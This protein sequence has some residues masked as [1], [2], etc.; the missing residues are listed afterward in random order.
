MRTSTSEV[1][2]KRCV[3]T[4]ES[5]QARSNKSNDLAYGVC[6]VTYL[7]QFRS[8]PSIA[9][10]NRDVHTFN[11]ASSTTPGDSLQR[12]VGSI[13]SSHDCILRWITDKTLDG[14]LL[15]NGRLVQARRRP[16]RQVF[17]KVD[18][19]SKAAVCNREQEKGRSRIRMMMETTTGY[20]MDG[21]MDG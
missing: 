10:I 7:V 18:I 3:S 20:E 13:L 1:V 11:F 16:V 14:H 4:I 6:R 15:D 21:W 17:F 9:S 8:H 2:A 19:W 12:N 5:I